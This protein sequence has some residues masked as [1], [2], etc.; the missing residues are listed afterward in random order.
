MSAG[1][2][3]DAELVARCRAGDEGA[4]REMVERFSRYIYAIVSRAYGLKDRDA[5][6]VFQDV[7]ARAYEQ[8]HTLRDDAAIRPWLA[9]LARRLAV[10]RLRTAGPEQLSD[11]TEFE[12]TD[13]HDVIE[14]LDEALTVHEALAHLPVPCREL[15]D[16]FFARDQSYRTLSERLGLPQ[17]TVAS[18]IS[19]CLAKLGAELR[20]IGHPMFVS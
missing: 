11:P 9:Q 1:G 7:F 17:G 3:S 14:E 19:R 5:E 12:P 20:K 4:W 18:R 15:L 8:L 6:D 2:S 10:D 16:G 13:P